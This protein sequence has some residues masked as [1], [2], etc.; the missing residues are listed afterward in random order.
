MI[1]KLNLEIEDT[2]EDIVFKINEIIEDFE[3]FKRITFIHGNELKESIE[4][5]EDCKCFD[6][7]G[8][9]SRK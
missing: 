6:K 8:A 2:L 5:I 9:K 7:K 3:E 1:E 4:K